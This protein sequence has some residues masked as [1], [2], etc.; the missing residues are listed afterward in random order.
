MPKIVLGRKF[1]ARVFVIGRTI[2]NAND[3]L[4]KLL[5]EMDTTKI[6]K[7]IRLSPEKNMRIVYKNG[8]IFESFKAS[9][10]LRGYRIDK[11]YVDVEVDE[12]FIEYYIEPILLNRSS[13]SI[14]F[15]KI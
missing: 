1:M 11:D 9:E 15:F 14:V 12:D 7:I 5:L 2:E 3:F 8:D 13:S 10:N 4:S 6:E